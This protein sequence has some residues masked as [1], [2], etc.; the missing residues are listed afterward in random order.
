MGRN[1]SNRTL[2]GVPRCADSRSAW[3][4][5]SRPRCSGVHHLGTAA[6]SQVL[7]G[8]DDVACAMAMIAVQAGHVKPTSQKGYPRSPKVRFCQVISDIS[9][10]FNVIH[11]KYR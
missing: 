10:G 8:V 11:F 7:P 1:A 6:S 3:R 5:D 9:D 4:C 2:M